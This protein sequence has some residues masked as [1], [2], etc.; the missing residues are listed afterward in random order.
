MR[1][2]FA[3]AISF[4]MV[5]WITEATPVDQ[6]LR[7]RYKR[8]PF[9]KAVMEMRNRPRQAKQNSLLEEP[10]SI[11]DFRYFLPIFSHFEEM[12]PNEKKIV[13]TYL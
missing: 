11:E 1:L 8:I 3:L 10:T 2:T 9:A 6:T 13:G 7:L 5:I 12:Y 4:V